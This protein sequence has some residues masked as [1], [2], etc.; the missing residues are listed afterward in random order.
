MKENCMKLQLA[1]NLIAACALFTPATA[2]FAQHSG[3]A[4]TPP[5]QASPYAGEQSRE[6]KSLSAGDVSGLLSGAGMAYAKAAELNGYPGPAHVLELSTQLQLETQQRAATEKLMAEHK[7]KAR[8]MGAQLVAA[9]RE[10]DLAFA[11]KQIDALRINELTQRIGAL[12]A[13]LRAEHLQTHLTQ[14]ALL[15]PEQI[16]S[17]QRLRGYGQAVEHKH[18]TTH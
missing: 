12:Q 8:A 17:Y 13:S 16:A 5:A 9:E 14:T 1:I 7:A 10:L 15:S 2:I 11:Q 18:S 4:A 3:H 6:I